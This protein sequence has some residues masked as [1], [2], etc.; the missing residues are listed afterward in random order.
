MRERLP[1]WA[2]PAPVHA[3]ERVGEVEAFAAGTWPVVLTAVS[4][5]YDG[6]G[7][8]VCASAA[9]PDPSSR[10]AWR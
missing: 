3:G 2:S 4:G 7:V 1:A 9:R 8:W 5:G 6:K 10:T